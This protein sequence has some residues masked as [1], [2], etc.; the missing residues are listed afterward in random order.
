MSLTFDDAVHALVDGYD[1]LDRSLCLRLAEWSLAIRSNNAALLDRLGRYFSHVRTTDQAACDMTVIAIERDPPEPAV[2]FVDWRREPGKRG[3][4]DS[5]ADLPG[6]RLLRKVRTGMVFAQS[7]HRLVA[8]GPCLAND[9]QLINFVNSQLMNRLQHD[10]WLICHA[11][12]LARAGRGLAIAGLS[13]GGKSTLML[14]L[15]DDA[16]VSFVS[17]DRLFVRRDADGVRARGIPKLPRINPGTIV[18]NPRL[19]GLIPGPRRAELSD[20]PVEELW[21]LEE[22]HDVMI[23]AVYGSGRIVGETSLDAFV[24]I[25]WARGTAAP[26]RLEAV[27]VARRRDL[28]PAVMKSPG[29]F[30]QYADGRFFS[31]DTPLDPKPY[32]AALADVPFYEASGRIDFDAL[33]AEIGGLEVWR[34]A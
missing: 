6:G 4:K 22:K 2:D 21:S 33:I 26:T 25:I 3:R 34:D 27:D 12:G 16:K 14:R 32:L 15:M 24:V 5:Y 31:D 29:P 10:D 28:L 19:H 17:N 8:A 11:A 20:L 30:Y 7:E 1:L 13:G 9:N 18:A 23:D